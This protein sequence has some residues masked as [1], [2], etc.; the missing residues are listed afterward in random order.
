VGISIEIVVPHIAALG[1]CESGGIKALLF[2]KFHAPEQVATRCQTKI[3]IIRPR[4]N[5]GALT[6]DRTSN[7]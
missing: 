4:K 7:R 2:Q 6:M 5:I 1:V 3:I